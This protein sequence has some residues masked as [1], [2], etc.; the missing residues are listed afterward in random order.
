MLSARENL[1]YFAGI[2]GVRGRDLKARISEALDIS[3]LHEYADKPLVANF[4]GGMR[5]R[6]NLA[7]GLVHRP[8]LLLLDE[9]TVGVDPQ[10]RNLILE[11]V[12]RLSDEDGMSVL[13]TTHYIEEAENLCERVAIM[14]HGRILACDT[15]ERLVSSVAGTTI[16]VTLAGRHPD[17]AAL[18]SAS[19]SVTGVTALDERSYAVHVVDQRQGLA[20]LVG[21]AG[22][23][24]LTYEALRIIPP[25]LE[26]VFLLMTGH[27]LRDETVR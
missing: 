9:P 14:D 13:L 23:G 15:V 2:Q 3:G 27:G 25:S 10:S 18:L 5:R 7:C 26:R 24:E 17:F 21:A 22:R 8:R 1:E 4:S 11:N 12:R 16:E 6:L 20:A 19:A